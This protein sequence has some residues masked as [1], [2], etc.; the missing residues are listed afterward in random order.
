MVV[1]RFVFAKRS[2]AKAH[3]T[4]I[5]LVAVEGILMSFDGVHISG[6]SWDS[7]TIKPLWIFYGGGYI[8]LRPWWVRWWSRVVAWCYP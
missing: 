1:H 4:P 3:A 8:D 7:S 6:P 5:F 2:G